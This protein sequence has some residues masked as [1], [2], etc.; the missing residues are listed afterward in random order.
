[1]KTVGLYKMELEEKKTSRDFDIV[2]IGG[3]VSGTALFYTL[4]QFSDVKR[5]ALLEKHSDLGK[6]NSKATHNSQTLHFGDIETNYSFEKSKQV[7]I[8]TDMLKKYL[9][10]TKFKH[11]KLFTLYPKMVLAVG[12]EEVSE[13]RK[14]FEEFKDLFP[15][16]K[17]IE[18]SEIAQIEPNV[19]KNRPQEEPIVALYSEEGYTVDYGAL[20]KAFVEDS[21]KEGFE[22]FT[23]TRLNNIIKADSGKYVIGTNN[24]KFTAK[25][26]MVA[27]GGH[28]LLI[29]KQLGYGRQYAIL[30]I[31][32]SFYFT[33]KVLNGKVYTVQNPKLPFAAVHGD[34]EVHN[35]NQTRWGPTA[36]PIAM[37]ERY[38]YSSVPEYFRTFGFGWRQFVTIAKFMGDPVIFGYI[39]RNFCYDIPYFGK[40][41][42]LKDVQKI[43]PSLK[44]SQLKRAKRMGGTRPQVIDKVKRTLYTGEARIT[45]DNII[46]NITPSPGASTCLGNAYKDAQTLI[47][48][49]NAQGPKYKF[50]KAEFDKKF[51]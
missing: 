30:S 13:L 46:F 24:G 47:E 45:E 32:G 39:F 25:A 48:F 29:A 18:R 27:A 5:V 10:M 38:E 17:L 37:L 22:I 1:M 4:S 16:L 40:R 34:P 20:S 51:L 9:D 43:V 35:V 26:V 2:I 28:S 11:K 50:N 6:V 14:R 31:A 41:M 12:N 21:K 15:K 19:V 8:N 7:K 44:P 42:F 36:K 49:V 3:G 33:D 23:H